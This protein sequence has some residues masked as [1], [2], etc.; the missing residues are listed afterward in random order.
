MFRS[1]NR[2]LDFVPKNGDTLI[3][4][5]GALGVYEQRGGIP[6]VCGLTFAPGGH[7]RSASG[8][9]AVKSKTEGRGT[10]RGRKK[11]KPLPFCPLK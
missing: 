3:A 9:R 5:G 4:V 11:K 6:T 10:F 8:V 7:W 2:G 1:R